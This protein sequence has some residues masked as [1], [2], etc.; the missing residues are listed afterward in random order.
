M[1]RAD[2]MAATAARMGA[3]ATH[4][5]FAETWK[6]Q[7]WNDPP[8]RAAETVLQR[9]RGLAFR[10]AIDLCEHGDPD[11][12]VELRFWVASDPYTLH[13]PRCAKVKLLRVFKVARAEASR[14]LAT[15]ATRS[16]RTPWPAPPSSARSTRSS[17]SASCA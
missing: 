1:T 7:T 3:Q 5:K 16:T 14:S 15:T 8:S 17:F 6:L 4:P 9:L 13:C 2:E 10:D 12:V 11:A